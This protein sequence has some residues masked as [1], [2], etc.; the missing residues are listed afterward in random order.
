M[1]L[2]KVKNKYQI[3]IPEDVRKK[4]KVKIGDMLE[5]YEKEGQLV[6]RPVIIV[7]KSQAYFWTPEWQKAEKE[8]DE[9]IRKGNISGPFTTPDELL[10]HL[11][12]KAK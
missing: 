8:A 7:D 9:D 6:A 1:A 2:V 11:K 4:L 12:K 3:V 5:V 10:R